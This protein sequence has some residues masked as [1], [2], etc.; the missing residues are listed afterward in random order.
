MSGY[1]FCIQGLLLLY[2][3]ID[4]GLDVDGVTKQRLS[5]IWMFI[6]Y[7]QNVTREY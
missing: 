2:F 1:S 7:M 5:A 6:V 3:I 4:V